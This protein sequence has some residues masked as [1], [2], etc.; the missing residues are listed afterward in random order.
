M[1]CR[2]RLHSV[3]H[4]SLPGEGAADAAQCM[5]SSTPPHRF[6]SCRKPVLQAVPLLS[7]L[8]SASCTPCQ[9]KVHAEATPHPEH[10]LIHS[11]L[12]AC[13]LASLCCRLCLH[14]VPEVGACGGS[15]RGAQRQDA[16]AWLRRA[17]GLQVCRCQAAREPCPPRPPWPCQHGQLH[18]RIC[19]PHSCAS[20]A[21]FCQSKSH[22][23]LVP[24]STKLR[25]V[26]LGSPIWPAQQ[27]PVHDALQPMLLVRLLY[28]LWSSMLVLEMLCEISKFVGVSKSGSMQAQVVAAEAANHG[29]SSASVGSFRWNPEARC[30]RS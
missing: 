16:A 1:C 4:I 25:S 18:P 14:P 7:T 20:S 22:S 10:A 2:L 6:V 15:H 3:L 26:L 12:Y 28:W 23:Q 21:Q 27:C 17:P 30:Q 29:C 9:R 5:L 8:F 24:A 13:Q 11:S 19:K